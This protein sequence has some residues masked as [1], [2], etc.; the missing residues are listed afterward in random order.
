M[1][2]SPN[3]PPLADVVALAVTLHQGGHLDE[4]EELYERALQRDPRQVDALHFLGVLRHRQGNSPEAIRLIRAALL[5]NP[6]Y[7]GARINLGNVLKESERFTEAENEYR[8]VVQA[9]PNNADALN[10]LGVVLRAQQ[11]NQA[12]IDSFRQATAAAPQHAD[13]H[14]NLGNAL[15]AVGEFEEALT[16]FRRAVEIDPHHTR[17]HL[18]LGRALYSCNRIDEAVVVYRQWLSIEPD[19]PIAQHM[20]VSCLGDNTPDRCSTDFVKQ[21]FDA[22]A[23]SFDEVLERLEYKA[24]A[25]VAAAVAAALPSPAAQFAILDAGCGTG[26]C[27]SALRPYANH[28]V[29][30]DLSPNM[31]IKAN[32][33]GIYDDLCEVELTQ[34]MSEHA[35]QFDVIVSADTLNYFGKLDPVFE[36]AFTALRPG[37]VLVFTLE[38]AESES[39][40]QGY[41]LNHHGRYSHCK[42]HT[43]GLLQ[44]IGF[45]VQAC[46]I[47]ELRLELKQSVNGLVITVVKPPAAAN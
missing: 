5:G 31:I 2:A 17:A 6:S 44:Q 7:W 30:I 37:G 13:A 15:R 18:S 21:S 34:Y 24:P 40:P 45:S 28:L 12:A 29:G 16:E 38:H 43:L 19:N 4:A 11:Q 46:D 23:S 3:H 41:R 35:A 42:D 9:L 32:S 26:L 1:P 20:L 14:Q 22:F 36:T 47:A 39:A 27:G 25:L 10:N 8:K 33:Q